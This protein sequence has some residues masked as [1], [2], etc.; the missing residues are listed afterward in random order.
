MVLNFLRKLP[1]SIL[2]AISH[3]CHI[4]HISTR[5][6]SL[7]PD[8]KAQ[9]LLLMILHCYVPFRT[10]TERGS[11]IKLCFI[12]HLHLQFVSTYGTDDLTHHTLCQL[13]SDQDP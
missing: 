12:D 10:M 4:C 9:N 6:S 3:S 7:L 1:M 8:I 5:L 2:S 11:T 13:R